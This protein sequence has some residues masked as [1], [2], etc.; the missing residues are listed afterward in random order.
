VTNDGGP[1]YPSDTPIEFYESGVTKRRAP[2]MSLR[3]W[4][5]GQALPTLIGLWAAKDDNRWN[6]QSP[7]EWAYKFADAMLRYRRDQ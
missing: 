5:A 4:F 1:A 7:A 2:G 3:D 6:D